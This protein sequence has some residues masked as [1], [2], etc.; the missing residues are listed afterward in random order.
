MTDLKG[1]TFF[2][3]GANTGIGAST[4]KELARRGGRVFL[5]CRS[6]EK[7]RPVLEAIQAAG[8]DAVFHA[9]DLSDLDDVRRS[10]EAFL[11]RGEPLHVL[12]N[13]AGVAGQRGLTKQGFELQFGTNHMGHFLLTKLL[14]PRLRE[15]APARIVNVAS[16]AHY[17]AEALN[18]DVLRQ[19]TPSITGL[20]E[21]S[22]SKLCNVLFTK[23]LAS[24]KAGPGVTS[25][26]LHPGVVASDAWR[27]IPWPVR[28]I[29]KMFMIT[30]EDGAKTSLYCAASP[31]V[32][33]EDGLYYDECKEKR[34]SRLARD[35][36]LAKKLWE[37]SEEYLDQFAK[38]P[39]AAA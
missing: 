2:V 26:A 27:R 23:E 33:K 5:A 31:D 38:S 37:K 22:V 1:R 4:V 34:P 18:F 7:T 11:E 3:T 13:N 15:S 24:G 9:L 21:Y 39:A 36:E 6:E 32:A 29:M 19:S 14:L 20:D 35:P 25:Y 17:Q 8:G 16:K 28:S 10:A 30:N 12:L